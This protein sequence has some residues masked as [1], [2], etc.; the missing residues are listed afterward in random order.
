MK[1]LIT[2]GAGFIG[3]H[4]AV[5][6]K[7]QYNSSIIIAFD[8]LSRRGSE[9]N[10]SRLRNRGIN[11]IHGDV[12]NREDISKLPKFDVLIDCAAEPSVL[13]GIT[14]SAI[15]CIQTNIIGTAHM[16]EL[17]Q[18]NNAAIIFMSTSR[19]YPMETLAQLKITE[20]KTRFKLDAEQTTIGA[21]ELG[22]SEQFP[23]NGIRSLYGTTKLASEY[24]IQEYRASHKIK[25]VINRCSVVTGPGQMGK[26]DQGFIALWVARHIYSKPIHYIGFGGEGKQVRDILHVDDLFKLINLQIQQINKFDGK[27]FNIGGGTENSIS[28]QELTQLCENTIG[29]KIEIVK[30]KTTRQND[31]PIYITD[32]SAITKHCGWKPSKKPSEIIADMVFWIKTNEKELYPYFN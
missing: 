14:S 28:L 31:L 27:A 8:N 7:E 26:T 30:D 25:T 19:V 20:E 11:F 15:G 4:L 3:T 24:L 17:V 2:G 10:L 23:L 29:E 13:A 9:L 12:R 21:S 16:L 18:K 6:L 22:V 5:R 1:I 32:N